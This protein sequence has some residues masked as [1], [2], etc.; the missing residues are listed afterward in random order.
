MV[1]LFLRHFGPSPQIAPPTPAL[2]GVEAAGPIR[3]W[4][5]SSLRP[6]GAS[7]S[8]AGFLPSCLSI[9]TAGW[10]N[11]SR[12]RNESV[13]RFSEIPLVVLEYTQYVIP[14]ATSWL[15]SP[16]VKPCGL[17]LPPRQRYHCHCQAFDTL[18]RLPWVSSDSSASSSAPR[19]R[20]GSWSSGWTTPAR[21]PSSRSCPTRRSPTSC[22]RRVRAPSTPLAAHSVCPAWARRRHESACHATRSITRL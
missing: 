19:P 1:R 2:P 9:T 5:I 13:R 16:P 3:G 10:R 7:T 21:R 22:R 17:S 6:A 15:E 18:R 12:R 4:V 20:L 11:L 8:V 14:I